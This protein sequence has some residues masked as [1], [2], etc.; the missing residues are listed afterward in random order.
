MQRTTNYFKS[1]VKKTVALASSFEELDVKLQEQNKRNAEISEYQRKRQ[2]VYN[3]A[4]EAADEA[5]SEKAAAVE[6]SMAAEENPSYEGAPAPV[7][8]FD[9]QAYYNQVYDAE[10]EKGLIALGPEPQPIENPVAGY[11]VEDM[12][13]LKEM[14]LKGTVY[15]N[16]APA[17]SPDQTAAIINIDD[18]KEIRQDVLLTNN[19]SR[20]A[21]YV[22]CRAQQIFFQGGPDLGGVSDFT[23]CIFNEC[24]FSESPE[25]A[26]IE[27]YGKNYFYNTDFL[28]GQTVVIHDDCEFYGCRNVNIKLAEDR[29]Y[30]LKIANSSVKFVGRGAGDYTSAP[31]LLQM[32][33]GELTFPEFQT[34]AAYKFYLTGVRVKETQDQALHSSFCLNG[35]IVEAQTRLFVRSAV[36]C[37][38]YFEGAAADKIT[39]D[40]MVLVGNIIEN[41]TPLQGETNKTGAVLNAEVDVANRINLLHY[42]T[43]LGSDSRAAVANYNGIYTIPEADQGGGVGRSTEDGQDSTGVGQSPFDIYKEI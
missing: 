1:K 2:E 5:V 25:D 32:D 6:A 30:T 8:D 21:H 33:G 26:E 18:D 42:Q 11:M 27:F 15:K 7:A 19:R 29:Q 28:P 40:G 43:T 9:A 14:A 16:I 35:C 38:M 22:N 39:L 31:L 20:V 4:E 13:T 41:G 3:K 10:V 34:Y 36:G 37:I 12:L 23:D 24:S 17:I